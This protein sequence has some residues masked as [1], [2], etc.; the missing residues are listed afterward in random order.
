MD[1]NYRPTSRLLSPADI[2]AERQ[3][4]LLNQQKNALLQM[5]MEDA[6]NERVQRRNA[7]MQQQQQQGVQRN[8][9]NDMAGNMGPPQDFQPAALMMAGFDPKQI[10]M[11]RGPQQK[12]PLIMGPGSVALDPNTRQPVFTAPFKPETPKA[13]PIA[14]LQAHR[15]TLPPGSP[16]RREAQALI[17]NQTRPPKYAA[18]GAG[19]PPPKPPKPLPST[20]LKMQQ[21]SLDKIGI[22]SSIN[23]D[24]AG[25]SRQIDEGKLKFGPIDNLV[26]TGRNLAGISSEQS[27]NFG[28]FKSTLERLR[29]ESLRLNTGV[30]TDGDA[31]RAW[32]ELFQ[33]IN[34]TG[35]VKQRLVELQAINQRGA[36]LQ[37]LRV[38]SLRA[39][40]GAEPLDASAYSTQP[41]AVGAPA[42]PA[43]QAGPRAA[44]KPGAVEGGYRF[45]GGNPGDPKNWEQVRQGGASGSF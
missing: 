35:L 30:Q 34:D 13:P 27:R 40:H 4:A 41:A 24:L 36:E 45:K 25:I 7:L 38:D 42:A 14:E 26:N 12:A 16:A 20:V 6:Q 44:P 15:D 11:L 29:N 9:L 33:N 23:A 18:P 17:D 32:N 1:F 5:Q 8:M 21:E 43:P 39:E 2:Q 19:T 10:E 37:R 22:A 28:T 31:Q 3:A